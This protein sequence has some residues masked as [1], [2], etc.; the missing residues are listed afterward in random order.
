MSDRRRGTFPTDEAGYRLIDGGA[1]RFT[2]GLRTAKQ[3]RAWV[4]RHDVRPVRRGKHG[5]WLYRWDDVA[6]VLDDEPTDRQNPR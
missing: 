5:A 2:L 3:L 6:A 4:D 1:L